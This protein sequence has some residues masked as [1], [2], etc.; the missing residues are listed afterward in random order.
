MLGRMFERL[1]VEDGEI[2]RYVARAYYRAEVEA[3]IMRA[4]GAGLLYLAPTTGRGSHMKCGPKDGECGPRG[5][6]T[7]TA[8][9]AVYGSPRGALASPT[10]PMVNCRRPID[11][12]DS[13][14]RCLHLSQL[15]GDAG[16]G[17]YDRQHA[18]P[19][20]VPAGLECR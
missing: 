18:R 13:L 9:A 10:D 12:W 11:R 16:H 5:S 1:Y 2:V 15:G 20:H 7:L 4:V 19:L 17:V 3:I 14:P 8:F 6:R